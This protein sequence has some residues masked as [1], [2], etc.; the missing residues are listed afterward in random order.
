MPEADQEV[1]E[2]H[3]PTEN[4]T[5]IAKFTMHNDQELLNT[6][7]GM[8][9][10]SGLNEAEIEE[11]MKFVAVRH[12]EA[13]QVIFREGDPCHAFFIVLDG[14]VL[15]YNLS[16]KGKM[17]IMRICRTGDSFGDIPLFDGGPYP[18]TAQTTKPATLLSFPKKS[19]EAFLTKCPAVYM[20]I[21]KVFA[22]RLRLLHEQLE[23]LT[24]N[25]VTV[26]LARYLLKELQRQTR[27]DPVEPCITLDVSK[28]TLALHLGTTIETLS[29][30]LHKLADAKILRVRGNR[31]FIADLHRLR[32][33][34]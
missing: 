23:S 16:E 27:P 13:N 34:K 15:L 31:I 30:T 32:S 12:F 17:L 11:L 29:R 22:Q 26:R 24:L 4:F 9:L 33:L 21:L 5:T 7:G 3:C 14:L 10:L 8:P 1:T 28:G 2:S 20:K 19:F 6:I 25:E 18:I